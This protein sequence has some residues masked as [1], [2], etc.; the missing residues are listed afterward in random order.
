MIRLGLCC[1][2]SEVDIAF[3]RTTAAALRGRSRAVQLERLEALCRHN[4]QA[5]GA[6]IE[7]CGAHGIGA[8][9]INSQILPLRTQPDVGYAVSDLPGGEGLRRAFL[10]V[11]ERARSLGLRLSFHPDQ[12]VVLSSPDGDVR[13]RSIEEL[14]YQAEVAAWVG[15]D[16]ITIHGG[17]GYGDKPSA[18]ARLTR[19][20][21]NLDE[22]L[23]S[24]LA[25]ENDD[26]VYGVGDLLPVCRDLGVPLVYDLH[27]QRCLGEAL[28]IAA[29]TAAA[30]ATWGGREPHCHLSS[31]RQGWDGPGTTLHADLIDPGDFPSEWE[32]LTLTVDVEAKA[33]EV[34]VQRLRRDLAGRGVPVWPGAA[35][36]V[37][38][39][40][41]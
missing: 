40:P 6:A 30:V 24:R 7:Y 4:V 19:S 26:R 33:K 23:R 2:F 17:G 28:G 38:T 31:P 8:F 12:F 36:P 10:A 16:V 34:A 37:F 27:H 39:P 14:L 9:R 22:P 15:A 35:G 1:Q 13:R 5:L 21:G 3:R 32:A 20:I 11:G 25:L 18:L 29:S 41:G